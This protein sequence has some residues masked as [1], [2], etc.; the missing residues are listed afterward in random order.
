MRERPLDRLDARSA[1]LRLAAGRVQTATIIDGE[2]YA[3][4]VHRPL[5]PMGKTVEKLNLQLRWEP[6]SCSVYAKGC[7]EWLPVITLTQKHGLLYIPR[8][9]FETVRTFLKLSRAGDNSFPYSRWADQLGLPAEEDADP[10]MMAVRPEQPKCL[11]EASGG[12]LPQ[13]SAVWIRTD[14]GAKTFR[15]TKK[16][17]PQWSSVY[18]R[19]TKNAETGE[20]VADELV[21]NLTEKQLHRMLAHPT[22]LLTELHYALEATVSAEEDE[23]VDLDTE[24]PEEE[25]DLDPDPPVE[26]TVEQLLPAEHNPRSHGNYLTELAWDGPVVLFDRTVPC[27]FGEVITMRTMNEHCRHQ[28]LN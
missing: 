9:E 4:G 14:R 21:R 17:G 16:G 25:I 11:N 27:Q 5:C 8:R 23:C 10:T 24:D 7:T 12:M 15:T 22:N 2:I 19:V 1:R 13:G 18:R 6:T 3:A 20:V 26:E 28:L